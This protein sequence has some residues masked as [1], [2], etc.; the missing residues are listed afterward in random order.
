MEQ[1]NFGVVVIL[2]WGCLA[3]FCRLGWCLGTSWHPRVVVRR[4][5]CVEL[6]GFGPVLVTLRSRGLLICLPGSLQEL[7]MS[8]VLESHRLEE[9]GQN[10]IDVLTHYGIH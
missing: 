6:P 8:R 3:R 5:A 2:R 10:G 9:G 7:F 1:T 4:N